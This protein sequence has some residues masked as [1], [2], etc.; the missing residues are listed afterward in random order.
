MVCQT[1]TLSKVHWHDAQLI[2]V[3]VEF[4]APG[5]LDPYIHLD[6]GRD[7]LTKVFYSVALKLCSVNLAS[8]SNYTQSI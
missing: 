8:F 3:M 2:A 5:R 4:I 6:T 1:A 7:V